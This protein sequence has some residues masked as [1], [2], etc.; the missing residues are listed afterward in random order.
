MM[1]L[2]LEQQ[3]LTRYQI[4]FRQHLTIC[5]MVQL[6][7]LVL[8]VGHQAELVG[9]ELLVE[10]GLLAEQLAELGLLVGQQLVGVGELVEQ[11]VQLELG[12]ELLV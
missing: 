2:L 7:G 4:L 1:G 12:V 10:L 9:L 6:V 8:L 3:L 5:L 11:L